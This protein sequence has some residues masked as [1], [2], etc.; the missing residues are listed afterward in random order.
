MPIETTRALTRP[1]IQ[2]LL[3]TDLPRL[4]RILR[5]RQK[6]LEAAPAAL[7]AAYAQQVDVNLS[8]AISA[9][10]AGRKKF[11]F[12]SS[13]HFRPILK[14]YPAIPP[15]ERHSKSEWRLQTRHR[16]RRSRPEC[17]LR[18]W[19]ACRALGTK[20]SSRTKRM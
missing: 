8:P 1:L 18:A 9:I 12:S 16:P 13:T 15:N 10:Q 20:C 2:E 14:T 17:L 5:E 19:Y 4:E 3:E 7:L 11:Q 6:Y